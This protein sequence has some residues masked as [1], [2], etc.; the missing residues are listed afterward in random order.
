[1]ESAMTEVGFI[2]IILQ[3][4]RSLNNTYYFIKLKAVAKL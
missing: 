4:R 1:M 3:L 2:G